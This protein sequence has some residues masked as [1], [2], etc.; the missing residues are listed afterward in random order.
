MYI[1]PNEH[2]PKKLFSRID[3]CL[4]KHLAEWTF[5]EK[6]ILQNVHLAEWTFSGNG[7]NQ[8]LEKL[9][10]TA[11]LLDVQQLKGQCEASTVSGRQEG[12]GQLDSKTKKVPS[13]S[14]GQGNLVNKC[15]YNTIQY[16]IFQN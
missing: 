7:S 5:L 15:N 9:V 8:R 13:L 10:F 6:P 1:W 3:I 14:P 11:S 12:R 16:N 4:N 2:F